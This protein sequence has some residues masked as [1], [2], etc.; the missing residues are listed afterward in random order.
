LENLGALVPR[1]D[2]QA[3]FREDGFMGRVPVAPG[4]A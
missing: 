3:G 4:A 2:E 1:R